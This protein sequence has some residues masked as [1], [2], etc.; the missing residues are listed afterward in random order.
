MMAEL[1]TGQSHQNRMPEGLGIEDQDVLMGLKRR[2]PL[3]EEGER[4]GSLRLRLR[5]R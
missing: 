3:I 4:L 2:S 5:T 1:S